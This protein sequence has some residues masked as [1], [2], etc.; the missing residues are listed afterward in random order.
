MTKCASVLKTM[1]N[2]LNKFILFTGFGESLALAHHLQQEGKDVLVGMVEDMREAGEADAEAYHERVNR[3]A[4]YDGILN[5]LPAHKLLEHMEGMNPDEWFVIFDFNTLHSFADEAKKMGFYKGIFPSKLDYRLEADRDFAKDFVL[6]NYPEVKVAETQ[7]FKSIDDGI[8]FLSDTDEFWALKGN[9]TGATTVVPFAHDLENVKSELIDALQGDK[10][11]YESKGFIF[12]RQIRDGVNVCPQMI[13]YDGKRVASSIDYE[14]KRFSDNE[15]AEMFGCALN[16][17]ES[18]PMDCWLNEIAFPQA[19]DKLAKLHK[20]LFYIDC[21]LILK[22]GEFYYL[23]Y[24]SGRM[25]YDAV[26]AECEM[27]EGVAAYFNALCNEQNPYQS[28][29]GAGTRGFAQKR[30]DGRVKTDLA[31]RFPPEL[32]PHLWFFGA[33]KGNGKYV[34][35]PAWGDIENGIDLLSFTQAS[36]DC[37]YAVEKLYDVVSQFSFKGMYTRKDISC[38]YPHMEGI[39][40]YLSPRP[41]ERG[42]K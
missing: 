13:Y 19:T 40:K 16:I 25:G 39:K 31:M 6:K 29:Y 22:D 14:D 35:G 9:D 21:N 12:E 28:R 26:F 11:A 7:E 33:K 3:K 37:E 30:D 18:T 41:V 34:N 23:E 15:G 27:A 4:Q 1:P 5:K 10:Q 32:W 8:E 42:S 2:E 36:D 38:L 17:I 24:C 20:G